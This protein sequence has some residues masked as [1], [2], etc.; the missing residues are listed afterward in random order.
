M[1]D[2]LYKHGQGAAYAY[3]VRECPAWLR[4]R[5]LVRDGVDDSADGEQAEVP[6]SSGERWTGQGVDDR[7]EDECWNVL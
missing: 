1:E 2:G 7:C 3:H 4:Q 5:Q 6:E